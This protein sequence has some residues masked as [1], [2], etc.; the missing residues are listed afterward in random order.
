[1]PA[2]RSSVASRARS[3]MRGAGSSV[4]AADVVAAGSSEVV[5]GSAALSPPPT[6]DAITEATATAA[7][8]AT[9]SRV[10]ARTAG[11]YPSVSASRTMRS[12][13]IRCAV[14]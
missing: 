12:C 2:S 1:M 3:G 6:T 14:G 11:P 4:G 10:A 8:A 7:T 9:T 13:S 5:S